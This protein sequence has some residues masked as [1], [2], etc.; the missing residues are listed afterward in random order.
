M[1]D[2]VRSVEAEKLI[3]MVAAYL[4]TNQLV[5]PPAWSMFVKTSVARQEPPRNPDWWFVR[6][7]SILR[8]LY[9][10]GPLGVSRM[11]KFYGGRHRGHMKPPHFAKGSR[12]VVRKILQQLESA[13]LVSTQS[14]KGRVLTPAGFKVLEQAAKS[15]QAK[16]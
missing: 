9:L 4:K 8:K 1:A 5:K 6:A 10:H 12:A 2:V 7:A 11:R 13:G 3:N 16:K 15:L 14:R